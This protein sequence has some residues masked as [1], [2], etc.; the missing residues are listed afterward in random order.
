L[1]QLAEVLIFEYFAQRADQRFGGMEP[2][3]LAE[4]C[5]SGRDCLTFPHGK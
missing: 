2:Q 5:K 3:N 4:K 1:A